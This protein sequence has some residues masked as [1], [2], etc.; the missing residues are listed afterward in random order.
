MKNRKESLPSRLFHWTEEHEF[1]TFCII[2]VIA[3]SVVYGGINH[4]RRR[5]AYNASESAKSYAGRR[6]FAGAKWFM[7]QGHV[8][9][10]EEGQKEGEG[11]RVPVNT[12]FGCLVSDEFIKVWR[13]GRYYEPDLKFPLTVNITYGPEPQN[14]WPESSNVKDYEEGAYLHFE[15]LDNAD[16]DVAGITDRKE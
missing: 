2:A 13:E 10:Y 12:D 14:K 9:L 1:L 11:L 6:T 7:F 8:E 4:L 16:A 15:V 5:A 3:V